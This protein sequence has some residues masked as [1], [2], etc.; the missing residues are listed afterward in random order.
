MPT[1]EPKPTGRPRSA[2]RLDSDIRVR[3][4]SSERVAFDKLVEAWAR[5]R[6]VGGIVSPS[7]G[8]QLWFRTIVRQMAAEQ[9]IE[10]PDEPLVP[11]KS[12]PKP[13]KKGGATKRPRS[14]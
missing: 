3:L 11:A 7:D 1:R 8:N 6:A 12:T 14:R 10:I 9:G 13:A 2:V 4:T 5:S